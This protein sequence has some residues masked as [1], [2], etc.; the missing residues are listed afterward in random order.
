MNSAFNFKCGGED[1]CGCVSTCLV[2]SREENESI[3]NAIWINQIHLPSFYLKNPTLPAPLNPR[4]NNLNGR[5][6]IPS[7]IAIHSLT[8]LAGMDIDALGCFCIFTLPSFSINFELFFFSLLRF[9]SCC[10]CV[11]HRFRNYVRNIVVIE[12][13]DS[14]PPFVLHTRCIT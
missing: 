12:K 4:T 6:L 3:M 5:Q 8:Q 10:G 1:F 9:I 14:F 7:F 13:V 2:L 11:N